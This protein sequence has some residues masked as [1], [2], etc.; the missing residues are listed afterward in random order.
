V[1][2][3]EHTCCGLGGAWSRKDGPLLPGCALC[4]HSPTYWRTYRA[5]GQPYTPAT[6]EQSYASVADDGPR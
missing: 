5:D 4:E 1:D 6:I 2:G 3:S